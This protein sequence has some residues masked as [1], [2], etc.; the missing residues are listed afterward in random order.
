MIP[1]RRA[2]AAAA[3]VGLAIAYPF[4]V[5]DFWV[6]HVAGRTLGFG[7]IVLSMVFLTAYTGMLSLAQLTIAAVTGYA[8]AF[9]TASTAG[10][11]ALLPWP[12]ALAA[13]LGCAA[14]AG[15]VTGLLALRTEGVYTLMITL[16]IAMA[17]YYLTL[18]NYTVFNGFDG[19][20]QVHAPVVLGVSFDQPRPLYFLC[21]TVATASY[22]SILHI[23]ASPLG[24][25][26]QAMRDNP[27]RLRA[28]GYPIAA[29]RLVAFVIAGVI[30]GLGGLLSVWLNGSVSPG[31]AGINATMEVL[32]AAVLGGLRHPIGA[33]AGAFA[34]AVIQSF[35]IV[36]TGPERFNTIIGL[37]FIAVIVFSPDGLVGLWAAAGRSLKKAASAP[38]ARLSGKGGFQ[39]LA[40]RRGDT[41]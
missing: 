17:F 1:C 41:P 15:F 39:E 37:V 34:F 20:S 35:A 3:L 10:A 36:L 14:A 9:C 31:T 7:A 13:A 25:A 28:L 30:A 8:F 29:L 27:R 32:I 16:A 12:A 38:G 22:Y 21:L 11:E 26:L 6:L 24:L 33:F 23:A 19:F 18:Q 2:I 5:N 40:A 4:A